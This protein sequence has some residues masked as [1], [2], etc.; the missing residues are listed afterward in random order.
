MALPAEMLVDAWRA[1]EAAGHGKKQ[2]ILQAA[3]DRLNVVE[4]VLSQSLHQAQARSRVD[5]AGAVV[6]GG[7]GDLGHQAVAS[8]CNV[9]LG[10]GG[11]R[12]THS[13]GHPQGNCRNAL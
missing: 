9:V 2:S 10:A 13:D 1:A 12:A 5:G 8:V 4:P 6:V 11:E 3:A 7:D